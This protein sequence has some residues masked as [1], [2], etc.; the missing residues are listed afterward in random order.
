MNSTLALIINV[1]ILFLLYVLTYFTQALSGK[2][3]FYGISLNYDYFNKKEFKVLDK[4]YKLF[5]TIGFIISLILELSSIYIFKAYVAS[6]IL[7]MLVFCLYN[8]FVYINIHNKVKEL[9]SKLSF[10]IS[11]LDLEKNNVM[12]DTEF[13][14]EKNIIVKRYS[15]LHLIPLIVVTIVGVYV[16]ASY[17]SIPDVIPTHWGPS[18]NADAFADKSF[19]KILAIVGMMIGLGVVIYISSISSLKTRAKL[20]I[21]SIDNSKKAHLHYLNMFGFTFLVLNIGCEVLFID[22]LI[23]TMNASSVNPLILWP[24]T[25][26]IILTAN[27]QTYL[28]YKSPNKSKSA[29]YS[30]DDDDSLWIFGCIYNN[31]NDPSIFVNKRFGAGWTVNIGTTKGKIFFILPFIII[32]ISLCLV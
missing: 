31:S 21:N 24:T 19:I 3:Q 12:L 6:S 28:Y 11:D 13:I 5:T 32:L 27:Y 1:P 23:A 22:I 10:N 15:L 8:F 2:R 26:I 17:N 30:I 16:L 4:K 14:Q 29:S 20:S 9:K 18:G 7:P 25:I